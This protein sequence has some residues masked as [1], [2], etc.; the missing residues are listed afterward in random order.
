MI[1]AP[2][3]QMRL[4]PASLVFLVGMMSMLTMGVAS[5]METHGL[6]E[7]EVPIADESKPARNKA[8]RAAL[9]QVMIRLTGQRKLS[10][11]PMINR[12]LRHA[13][14]HVQQFRYRT[15]PDATSDESPSPADR[16]AFWVQFDPAS[17]DKVLRKAN[18]QPWGQ[19]KPSIL[20]WLAV[21]R[22]EG[23]TLLGAG[24]NNDLQ[25]VLHTRATERSVS[26][27]LPLLDLDDLSRISE[28]DVWGGSRERIIEASKRYTIDTV[29]VGRVLPSHTS[30][31]RWLAHWELLGGD[32][33]DNW[34]TRAE[35]PEGALRKGVD[36]AI[37]ILVARYARSREESTA[38]AVYDPITV[39]ILD[40][41]AVGDYA[42]VQRYLEGLQP[43]INVYV[44]EA[45][46]DSMTF[47]LSMPGGQ[48]KFDEMIGHGSTLVKMTTT[49]DPD[50]ASRYRLLP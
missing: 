28:T 34:T 40:I 18:I 16:L 42:R 11:H 20:I 15:E 25:D 50:D 4:I 29:L 3:R 8:M 38:D 46:I 13:E 49:I 41:R 2:C 10:N 45:D 32:L 30:P 12:I 35:K 21:K 44:T 43:R 17:V 19:I 24:D 48:T 23:R 31:T 1:N 5:S 9:L 14:R 33:I 7:I 26:I 6:Y 39:T 47:R 22:E 37:D 27:V 36:E